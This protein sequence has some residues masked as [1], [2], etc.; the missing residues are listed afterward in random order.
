MIAKQGKYYIYRHIR[1]DTNEPFYIGIGIKSEK[2]N[3]T[4]SAHYY[5]AYNKYNRKL[6]WKNIVNK[7]NYEVEILLESDDYEFIKQKE[8]EFIALYGRR[9][10]G[11]GSLTNLTDGGDGTKAIIYTQERKDRFKLG[12]NPSAKKVKN[13]K[14][15]EIFSSI[16]EAHST[17]INNISFGFFHRMLQ[18]LYKNTTDFVFIDESITF[19]KG[20]EVIDISNG[21]VYVSIR[22]ASHYNGIPFDRLKKYL[23]GT[24][25][26]TTNFLFLDDYQNGVIRNKKKSRNTPISI[27][28]IE[29]EE[30]YNSISELSRLSNIPLSTLSLK[31]KGKIYNDTPYRKLNN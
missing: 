8:I 10:L 28:N 15:G 1:L 22:E 21:V 24:H 5:R 17:I 2:N 3:R 29:T 9:D 30:I 27:I 26:N 13:V 25:Y 16:K 6:F 19:S 20:R 11:K 14:T 18:G 12:N 7:T 31:L 23:Y 4:I